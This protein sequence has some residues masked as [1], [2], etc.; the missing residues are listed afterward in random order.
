MTIADQSTISQQTAWPAIIAA[1]E[2]LRGLQDNWDGLG[3]NEVLAE[4]VD[5]SIAFARSLDKFQHPT[6]TSVAPTPAGSILFC[7]N[8][9]DDGRY[10]EVEVKPQGRM[11]FMWVGRDGAANH[12][13][14]KAT[15]CTNCGAWRPATEYVD[16]RGRRLGLCR[17]CLDVEVQLRGMEVRLEAMT[18]QMRRLEAEN[19]WLRGR[20]T[21]AD[22]DGR[23]R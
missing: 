7:W 19:E 9:G 16:R 18:S 12:A 15:P 23:D 11:S 13:D 10:R 6:P 14:L 4:V 1:I 2:S 3:A 8:A 17:R 21:A 20:A 5:R 22:L